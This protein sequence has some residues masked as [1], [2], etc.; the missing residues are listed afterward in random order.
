MKQKKFKM[1]NTADLQ[2]EVTQIEGL[3]AE[4]IFRNE[5]NGYTV[6]TL[7]DSDDTTAVGLLPYLHPGESVRLTG[8]W[9]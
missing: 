4:I 2:D 9:T 3:V 8:K 1:V 5:E 6:C 7:A